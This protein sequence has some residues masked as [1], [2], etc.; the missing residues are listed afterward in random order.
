[1][2]KMFEAS[3]FG[4][5]CPRILFSDLLTNLDVDEFGLI[6]AKHKLG[7]FMNSRSSN[8]KIRLIKKSKI[9]LSIEDR[10]QKLEKEIE[11]FNKKSKFKKISKDSIECKT[12][13]MAYCGESI[14][15]KQRFVEIY[16]E[17]RGFEI[18]VPTSILN[19]LSY[20]DTFLMTFG[21]INLFYELLFCSKPYQ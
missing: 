12:E 11:K 10:I 17:N 21:R 16:G 6:I 8:Y 4:F 19:F 2:L 5:L 18:A 3:Y 13:I 15:G 20:G 7:G 9:N 1:M 14:E